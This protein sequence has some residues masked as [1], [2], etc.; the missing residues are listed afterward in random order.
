EDPTISA[1]D[2]TSM[3]GFTVTNVLSE[4]VVRNLDPTTEL[5]IVAGKTEIPGL[6]IGVKFSARLDTGDI[7][8]IE[9]P[10][11]YSFGGNG[12]ICHGFTWITNQGNYLPN[13]LPTCDG[14]VMHLIVDEP[15]AYPSGHTIEYTITTI[16]PIETPSLVRNYWKA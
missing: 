6:Y 5:P 8:L 3:H 7:L 11:G 14:R 4:F 10:E 16:N 1:L 2:E 9:A 15:T 13:S 12:E